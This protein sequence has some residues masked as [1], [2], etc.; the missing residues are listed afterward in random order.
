MADGGVADAV[1]DAVRV[2]DAVADGGVADVVADADVGFQGGRVH[3]AS[4]ASGL[5]P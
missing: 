4:S 2:A 1:A 3:G 5:P